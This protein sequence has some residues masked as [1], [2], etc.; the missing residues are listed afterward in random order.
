M[1]IYNEYFKI[2]I[3]SEKLFYNFK[4][5]EYKDYN[6]LYNTLLKYI[7]RKKISDLYLDGE[8]DTLNDIGQ[9][10]L[11]VLANKYNKIFSLKYKKYLDITFSFNFN[12]FNQKWII[13]R[14]LK[15]GNKA[16]ASNMISLGDSLDYLETN[17][18]S[19]VQYKEFY[20][21]YGWIIRKGDSK[22]N[23][24]T[25]DLSFV[26]KYWNNYCQ[27]KH[28]KK[29]SNEA[30]EVYE[31]IYSTLGFNSIKLIYNDEIIACSVIFTDIKNKIVYFCILG[32]D[33]KYKS[34]SPGIYL[35]CKGIEFCN[36]MNYKFSFC[37]G[38]QDYKLKL[39]KFFGGTNGRKS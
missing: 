5:V 28:N 4:E 39:L 2:N 19:E 37:Y 35:Y 7:N 24:R 33:E 13:E 25:E 26:L 17:V 34:L 18:S 36:K 14:I 8:Y 30:L 3:L 21:K 9:V 23:I 11:L 20:N 27:K 6:E 12:I 31:D 1:I 10:V 38:L 16:F 32:W 15:I 22:T 29:F